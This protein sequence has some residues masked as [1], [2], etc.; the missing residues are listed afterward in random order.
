MHVPAV[1]VGE[2]VVASAET[3]EVVEVGCPAV[4]PFGDVVEVAPVGWR[5]AAGEHASAV[6]D[7]RGPSLE[8]GGEAAGSSNVEGLAVIADRDGGDV[9]VAAGPLE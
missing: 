9:G 1:G 4:A 5:V 8:V 6:A 3:G 2:S 7:H